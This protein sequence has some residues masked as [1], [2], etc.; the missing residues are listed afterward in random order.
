MERLLLLLLLVLPAFGRAQ[1][2]VQEPVEA[3]WQ[4]PRRTVG[5]DLVAA[6]HGVAAVSGEVFLIPELSVRASGGVWT[7]RGGAPRWVPGE[8]A[9]GGAGSV[10]VRCYPS[11]GKARWGRAFV[12]IELGR[13]Q[14]AVRGIGEAASWTRTDAVLALGVSRT[15]FNRLTVQ[16]HVASGPSWIRAARQAPDAASASEGPGRVAGLQLG[17]SW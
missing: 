2:Y 14:Y 9:E 1:D 4:G 17:W 5:I 7:G 16:A 13:E 12:G 15:W 10:G 8:V 3:T 11:S 6:A